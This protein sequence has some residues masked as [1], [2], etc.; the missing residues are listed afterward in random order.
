MMV[1]EA[2]AEGWRW[3]SVRLAGAMPMPPRGPPRGSRSRSR[4]RSPAPR[5]L[6][7]YTRHAHAPSPSTPA[8]PP[9]PL[10]EWVV[11]LDD[12]GRRSP[13]PSAPAQPNLALWAPPPRPLA[14]WVARLDDQLL[15]LSQ[16]VQQG[17]MSQQ[18]LHGRLT[19][20]QGEIADNMRSLVA[21]LR[22]IRDV[23]QG[24]HA[25]LVARNALPTSGISLPS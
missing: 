18:A 14:E 23:N 22:D 12:V 6:L 25:V 15:Q 2:M 17:L 4:S 1:A 3:Q 10:A 20:V 13:S 8:Q 7:A 11:R 24:I 5:R 19:T 21:V 9:P 16:Y